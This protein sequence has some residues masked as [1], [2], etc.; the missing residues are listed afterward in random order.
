MGRILIFSLLLIGPIFLYGQFERADSKTVQ[1]GGLVINASALEDGPIPL[2]GDWEIYWGKLLEPVDITGSIEGKVQYAAFPRLWNDLVLNGEELPGQGVATYRLRILFDQPPPMLAL[3]LPDFY[4]AYELWIDG[5]PVAHNGRVGATKATTEPHWL[6]QVV[7]VAT[8]EKELEI[9]LQVAN[10]HHIRGGIG[11]PILLGKSKVIYDQFASVFNL[12]WVIFGC[13]FMCGLFLLGLYNFKYGD[14]A[15]LFFALFCI[16]HSY[17]IIGAEHYALHQAAPWLPWWFTAKLEY[18]SLFLSIAFFWEYGNEILEKVIH[19]KVIQ[20]ERWIIAICSLMVFILPLRYYTFTLEIIKPVL[21]LSVFLGIYYLARATYRDGQA[22]VYLNLGI[23]ALLVVLV[24]TLLDFMRIW[25]PTP[26]LVLTAYILFLFFET[27][28]LSRRFANKF[29]LMANAADRANQ[30]K[31]EFL[32]TVSHEIRTPMNGVIG[33]AE[34]LGEMHLEEEAQRYVETI[35]L[36]GNN[37][38]DIINDILDLSKIEAE[39][40]DIELVPFELPEMLGQ[41]VEL[42][43]PK[44]E[45]KGLEMELEIQN[46]VPELL[47]GDVARIRQVYTN[48]VSNAIKFTEEGHIKLRFKI[49]Q[50]NLHNIL[51]RFEVEDT[52]IGIPNN[53]LNALFQPFSQL[54]P[55]ISR[56]YGGTGLGL[57]ISRRLVHLMGGKVK[58]E[59]EEGKG[60]TFT[61]TLPMKISHL[62][63]EEWKARQTPVIEKSAGLLAEELPLSILVAE[64]HPINQQLMRI[65]LQKLGFEPTFVSDGV[66]VLNTLQGQAFDLIFMDV[67]MPIMDGLEATRQIYSIFPLDRIPTI[68]AMTANALQGDRERCLEVGMHDYVAKPLKLAQIEGMIRKWGMERKSRTPA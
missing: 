6:P 20:V 16:A 15:T 2:S 41:I 47:E 67:Q 45:E 25:Q 19:T 32:A 51:G 39:R 7:P 38:V 46:T 14:K 66:G 18:L 65:V 34:L 42:L 62:D 17:R 29:R 63:V 61:V 26:F 36:S 44:A 30:A 4:T 37:L 3:S 22:M 43:S 24:G 13:L 59:S 57:A 11:E 27:L 53:R 52:G 68:I 64:D 56:K 50:Q 40:M 1:K 10:F 55:S 28:H 48:L 54:D 23:M 35:K 5:E 12:S 31:T 60:S 8:S 33:M 49:I 9:V 21:V 58:V